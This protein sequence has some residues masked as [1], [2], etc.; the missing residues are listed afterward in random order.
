[1]GFNKSDSRCLTLPIGFPR[2]TDTIKGNRGKH[3]QNI[4]GR[5]TNG[6]GRTE[7][8]QGVLQNR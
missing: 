8:G 3:G 6:M 1:L 5:L 7:A 2:P 4:N